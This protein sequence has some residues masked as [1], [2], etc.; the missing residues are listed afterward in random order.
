[1]IHLQDGNE[2]NRLMVLQNSNTLTFFVPKTALALSVNE[3]LM[4]SGHED[5]WQ[6]ITITRPVEYE[7]CSVTRVIIDSSVT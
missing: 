3:L 1:M 4:Q 5:T 2:S 7:D 6:S